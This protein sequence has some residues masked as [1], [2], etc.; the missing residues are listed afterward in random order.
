MIARVWRGETTAENAE[1]YL[2]YLER[3]GLAEYRRT[4]G[5]RG[6]LALRRIVDGRAQF[7]L[8]TLWESEEAVRSFAGDEISRAVFYP[9]DDRF[10]VARDDEVDHF[11]VVHQILDQAP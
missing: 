5:N 11:Q 6:V 3:T 2:A 9:E 8:L 4:P 7:L 10:L 1:P